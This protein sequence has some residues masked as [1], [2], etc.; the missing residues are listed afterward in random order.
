M[1]ENL[2][3]PLGIAVAIRGNIRYPFAKCFGHYAHSA[4]VPR[5]FR[6]DALIATAKLVAF[7]DDRWRA[8]ID[9]GH[10]DLVFT[11]GIFHTD[12]AE[13]AMTKVPGEITFSLNIGATSNMIMED[14]RHS[15]A[16]R[17]EELAREHVVTFD[18]GKRVGTPAVELDKS[19]LAQ[20]EQAGQEV[21]VTPVRM[22]TVGHDATMFQRR[23]IPASVLLVRNA[24]G[25]H[26]PQEHMEMADFEIGTKV[27]AAA[28]YFM[29]QKVVPMPKLV[30]GA[31]P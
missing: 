16:M 29:R 20:V 17:A 18:F 21:G 2:E 10:E 7:A 24:N 23:G 14:L 5:K 15:I 27:L 26:N 11:C 3:R 19:L 6:R 25:S 1:L 13:H 8:L 4:A 31:R 12:F 22:P 9:M 30:N 28:V